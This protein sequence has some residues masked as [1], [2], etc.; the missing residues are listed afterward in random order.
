MV[1]IAGGRRVDKRPRKVPLGQAISVYTPS[2]GLTGGEQS[3][4]DA[5]NQAPIESL[6]QQLPLSYHEE[7]KHDYAIRSLLHKRIYL[8]IITG[9]HS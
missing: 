6:F 2:S 8:P 7:G 3:G 5:S 1:R 9:D 4:L